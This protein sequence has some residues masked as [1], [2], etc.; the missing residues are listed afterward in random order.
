MKA[1]PESIMTK[2][3]GNLNTYTSKEAFM[4]D[5]QDLSFPMNTSK[6]KTADYH[7]QASA[8][9]R[10]GF[11][12]NVLVPGK[13]SISEKFALFQAVAMALSYSAGIPLTYSVVNAMQDLLAVAAVTNFSYKLAEMVK[14]VQTDEA[15][16]VRL[17]EPPP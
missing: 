16:T 9:A 8:K 7:G 2:P 5:M 6:E 17:G 4:V 3:K 11:L 14:K 12:P 1:T 13:T 10:A 15:V